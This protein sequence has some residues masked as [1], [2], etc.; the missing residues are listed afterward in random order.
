MSVAL[1]LLRLTHREKAQLSCAYLIGRCPQ[2]QPGPTRHS[3][4]GKGKAD[5]TRNTNID[6]QIDAMSHL[7]RRVLGIKRFASPKTLPSHTERCVPY[8]LRDINA[9]YVCR[10]TVL[11]DGLAQINMRVTA[12]LPDVNNITC[13]SYHPKRVFA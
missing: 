7:F 10:Y 5:Q 2:V 11:K 6:T 1:S 12:P 3:P 4:Y 13:E 9:T 8:A